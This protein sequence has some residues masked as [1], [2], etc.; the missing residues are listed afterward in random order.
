MMAAFTVCHRA[1]RMDQEINPKSAIRNPKFFRTL[2]SL[3][4]SPN[5]LF[6]IRFH[7]KQTIRN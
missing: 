6:I 7:A 5:K 1:P 4:F 2:A 3:C